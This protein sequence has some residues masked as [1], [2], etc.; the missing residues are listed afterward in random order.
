MNRPTARL[1]SCLVACLLIWTPAVVVAAADKP[2]AQHDVTSSRGVVVS[3]SREA[4][5]VGIEVLRR[6]GHAV[7]A[8]VATA[9]A[10]AVTHPAAGNI[11]GGGFMMVHDTSRC[12]TVC[13]EYRETAPS[14]AT[15]EIYSKLNGTSRGHLSAGVP[16]TV[17]GLALGH[18]QFG[19]CCWRDLV[20]PAVKLAA[21]GFSIDEPLAKSLNG[22]IKRLD[23][24]PE[25]RRVYSKPDGSPWQAGDRLVQ[26][27]L[28]KTLQLIADGGPNAFYCG[29]IADQIVAEMQAGGG[30]ISKADLACY[31]A[32]V[33]RPIHGTYRGYDV[34]APPPPS[35]GGIALVQMLNILEQFDLATLKRDSAEGTHLFIESMRRAY[36]DRARYIGDPAFTD[37]PVERLTSKS[38][39]RELAAGIDRQRATRSDELGRELL[40][41]TEGPST[42]HFS[43]VDADGNAVANTYTLQDSYGSHVVVRG[44]GFLLNNEMTDFNLQPGVTDRDGRIGTAANL[45]EPGKRMLSSQTPTLVMKDGRMV[46][47]TGTP[48][49]RTI[50]NTVLNVVTNVIDFGMTVRQAV[51]APRLHHQWLPDVAKLEP[52]RVS[53][54]THRELESRGHKLDD[55]HKQGDAHSIWIDPATGL[56]HGAADKR[57]SGHA[58]AE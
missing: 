18:E 5:E 46:L 29:P 24:Y 40:T 3:V 56:R 26:P 45:V 9:F 6:G 17:R 33:R 53:S 54:D 44:A 11:G 35:S 13:V 12:T 37:V 16:G 25:A 39:A 15:K 57:I 27:E 41:A 55:K 8:A 21:N 19:R 36:F 51:D 49:G 20:E 50:I 28:A 30:L 43:V 1:S 34:F 22:W 32:N 10:L 52:G 47:V 14:A 23:P 42:T 58:V 31:R 48:G 7:D 2:A 4:S 38:Y